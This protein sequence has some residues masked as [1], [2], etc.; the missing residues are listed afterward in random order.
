MISSTSDKIARTTFKFSHSRPA[1]PSPSNQLPSPPDPTTLD[2]SI[3]TALPLPRRM[4]LLV[5][6]IKPHRHYWTTSARPSESV[7]EY[8]L[9][10]G[11]PAIVVPVRPG[12]PLIGWDTLTL[13]QLHKIGKQPGGVESVKAK[14]VVSVLYE[15]LGLC[16]DWERVVVPGV[17][18]VELKEKEDV[19]AGDGPRGADE[20]PN[21]SKGEERDEIGLSEKENAL[22]N[23]LS[24][25]VAGAINSGASKEAKKVVDFER[26]GIVMFRIP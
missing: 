13:E 14:G 26:A 16:V 22:K 23:A 11:C 12:S 3:P 19:K 17:G 4:V 2:P 15:Y 18:E 10:N 20:E 21:E 24:L 7:I 5:L 9:L 1:S 6:G 8:L 25:L